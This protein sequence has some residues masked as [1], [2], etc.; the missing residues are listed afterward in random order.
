[1][2]RLFAIALLFLHLFSLYG[3]MM[4]YQYLVYKSDKL[5]NEQIAKN[6][7][8]LDDLFEVKLPVKMGAVQDWTD[9][10]YI[11]GQVQFKNGSYNYV[12]LKMTRD[13]VYLMCVPNYETTRLH[14]ENIINARKIADVPFG[15]KEHVP[16]IK[17]DG[18][19]VYNY[20]TCYYR[21]LTPVRTLKKQISRTGSAIVEIPIASPGEPP[22][23]SAQLS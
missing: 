20:Q 3:H 23:E 5:F 12:K 6:N 4:L 11:S 19:S 13:T 14:N 22:E 15:K 16:L 8:K 17:A 18:V 21:F 10:V 7:Y 2:K 9:Y 1:M